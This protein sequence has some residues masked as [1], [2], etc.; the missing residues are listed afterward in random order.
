M[1]L[2][3]VTMLAPR[4]RIRSGKFSP[5]PKGH[6]SLCRDPDDEN[7]WS[8]KADRSEDGTMATTNVEQGPT[9]TP[10]PTLISPI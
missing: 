3:K 5:D 7:G 1:P 9:A 4:V 10:C 6:D 8:G 2:P